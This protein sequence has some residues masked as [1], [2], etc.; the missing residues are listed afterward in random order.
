MKGLVPTVAEDMGN[1][2]G[3]RERGTRLRS[4][5]GCCA[6]QSM[7]P[8][9]MEPSRIGLLSGTMRRSSQGAIDRSVRSSVDMGPAARGYRNAGPPLTTD[10]A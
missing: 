9:Q 8:Y 10:K 1:V 4:K 6:P 7:V 2:S 5:Y 3:E